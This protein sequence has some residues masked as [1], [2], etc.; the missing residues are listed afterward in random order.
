M[1]RR[2]S[3]HVLRRVM[4]LL[5]AAALMQGSVSS[6]QVAWATE[7]AVQEE[8]AEA[9]AAAAIEAGHPVDPNAQGA[10]E[11]TAPEEEPL[12]LGDITVSADGESAYIDG[13]TFAVTDFPRP[14]G[15]EPRDRRALCGL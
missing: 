11:G 10:T 8:A 4:L 5:I 9:E 15:L 2:G 1:E 3:R 7:S 13:A 14:K 12:T 6:S